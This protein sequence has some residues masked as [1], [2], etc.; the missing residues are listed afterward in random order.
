MLLE[1]MTGDFFIAMD[2][3]DYISADALQVLAYAIER[4]PTRRIFYSDE[5]DGSTHYVRKSPY[6]KP[7]F[8]PVLLMNRCY[9]AHLLAVEADFLRKVEAALDDRGAGSC[10]Y[11]TLLAAL[12]LGEEPMHVRELLYAR[13]DRLD[14][15]GVAEAQRPALMQFLGERGLDQALSV[16]PN[17]LESASQ[18]WKL[19]A[20]E[21]LPNV[22]ILD[23][24]AAW[25]TQTNMAR[26]VAA[27]SEPGVDWLAILL[28]P[29][30]PR[31]L[32]ELSAVA[33]LDPRVAAVSGLLTDRDGD[34]VR[35]SGG[36]FLPGGRPF[37]PYAGKPLSVGG[38]HGQL[39]CQRCID[40][41]AP[42]N[43]LIRAK[44]LVQA[45]SRTP[46]SAGS[47]G[48]MVML[49]LLAHEAGDF[50]AV[51]P[52]L[53]DVLPSD[54][55]AMPPLDRHGLL[56]GAAALERGSRWYDARLGADPAYGL[57]DPA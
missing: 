52:H 5:Y 15:T 54:S 16:E 39:W 11:P 37:D 8:D 26:L 45:V 42:V 34:I 33:W 30:D 41:A 25:G 36:L 57:W 56:L 48:L 38:H 20:H 9:P 3:D 50:I 44:A 24:R 23:A 46:E 28:S 29:Q 18:T 17:T 13:R 49:G 27:A 10:A 14:W 51:T 32:L 43:V 35:W 1:A 12:A 21:P 53:R 7:D 19:T 40:V 6:F 4:N 47:D 55:F 31:A 2:P 22:K